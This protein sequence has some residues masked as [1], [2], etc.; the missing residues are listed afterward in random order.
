MCVDEILVLLSFL[1]S[2]S[3]LVA[4]CVCRWIRV[5]VET[6][7]TRTHTIARRIFGFYSYSFV[8]FSLNPTTLAI[9]TRSL[10]FMIISATVDCTGLVSATHT[11]THTHKE[12]TNTFMRKPA[13][14]RE[15]F[16]LFQ[17]FVSILILFN[18]MCDER[19]E[20]TTT[21]R[22]VHLTIIVVTFLLLLRF[23]FFALSLSL[24][25]F[26]M[27]AMTWRLVQKFCSEMKT[28]QLIQFDAIRN[29]FDS[30]QNSWKKKLKIYFSR[31]K[32]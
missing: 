32:I 14:R 13:R 31:L 12:H 1:V 8:S 29:S 21:M 19:I 11:L 17:I 23:F 22:L 26:S 4:V 16:E 9:S 5:R 24:S 15:L 10:L 18:W 27:F 30:T 28:S 25:V 2:T 20:R 7:H 3:Y 6:G